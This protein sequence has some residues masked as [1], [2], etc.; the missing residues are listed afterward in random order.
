MTVEEAA[1]SLGLSPHTIRQQIRDKRIRA[2]RFG[3]GARAPY[4]IAPREVER[5]RR[6]SLG[7]AHRPMGAKDRKPRAGARGNEAWHALADEA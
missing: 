3:S 4:D 6:E 7:Q 1:A 2:R 5:Y